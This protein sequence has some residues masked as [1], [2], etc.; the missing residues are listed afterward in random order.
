MNK[1]RS[2][3]LFIIAL[4][5]SAALPQATGE[6]FPPVDPRMI[7]D[8]TR[9]GVGGAPGCTEEIHD[10]YFVIGPDGERLAAYRKLH[11]YDAFGGTWKKVSGPVRG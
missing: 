1:V 8:P 4:L 6:S 3:S 11:L 9:I 7:G 10:R 2:L 5:S